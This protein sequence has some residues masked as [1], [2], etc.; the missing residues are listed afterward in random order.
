MKNPKKLE[1][2]FTGQ[3][4]TPDWPCQYLG[5][6]SCGTRDNRNSRKAE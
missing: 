5:A 3:N 6:T 1:R 4:G 2:N